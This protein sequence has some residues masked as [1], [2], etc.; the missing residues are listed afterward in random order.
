MKEDKNIYVIYIGIK[1]VDDVD[2]YINKISERIIPDEIDGIFITIPSFI[3]N[4]TK[5]ECINP[6]YITKKELIEK[7]NELI[8]KL[9]DKLNKEIEK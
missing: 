4:E 8:E 9:V 5:I 7:N 2:N 3:S 6:K 1:D